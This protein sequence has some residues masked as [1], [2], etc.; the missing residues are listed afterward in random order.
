MSKH[1][2]RKQKIAVLGLGRFGSTLARD[3]QAMGHEVIGIDHNSNTIKSLSA[4]L[5]HIAEAEAS[6]ADAL[7]FLGIPH[8]DAAVVAF[9]AQD[10]E[11]SILATLTLKQEM[12]IPRVIAKAANARHGEILERVG[13][14]EIKYPERESGRHLALAWSDQG[15][16]A[17]NLEISNQY[18][19]TRIKA[20]SKLH[21]ETFASIRNQYPNLDFIMWMDGEGALTLTPSDNDI[22]RKNHLLVIGGNP[23]EIEDFLDAVRE[24][25]T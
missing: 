25:S 1:H 2:Y 24:E 21:T 19:I 11:T 3:L 22:L 12:Q 14:D 23:N 5:F 10:L 6:D 15:H 17:D 13:A 9:S 7:K 16:E 20:P 4:E 8:C 18:L